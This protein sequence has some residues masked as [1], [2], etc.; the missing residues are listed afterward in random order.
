MLLTSFIAFDEHNCKNSLLC[1]FL[2]ATRGRTLLAHLG[3]DST[4]N[5]YEKQSRM[6]NSRVQLRDFPGMLSRQLRTCLNS[7]VKF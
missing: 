4:N 6:Q 1:V 2:L 7:A 5:N 3:Y